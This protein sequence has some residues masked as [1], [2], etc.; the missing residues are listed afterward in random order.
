MH[1]IVQHEIRDP[2][3]FFSIGPAP[4]GVEGRQMLPSRDRTAAVCLFEADSIDAVSAWL[5][6]LTEDVSINT[7]FE[8]D[9]QFALGLPERLTV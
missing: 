1:V 5:E 4:P 8:V 3:A 7:Y 6:P 2:G 9:S